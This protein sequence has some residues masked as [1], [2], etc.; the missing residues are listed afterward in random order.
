MRLAVNKVAHVGV[1]VKIDNRDFMSSSDPAQKVPVCCFV[2]TTEDDAD[3]TGF[4]IR[5]QDISQRLLIAGH[6]SNYLNIANV[7]NA[8]P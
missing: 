8:S 3:R 6:I 4:Q 5:F 7:G 2:T 1:G